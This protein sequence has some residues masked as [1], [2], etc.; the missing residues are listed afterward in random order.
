MN[1]SRGAR[2]R[3]PFLLEFFALFYPSIEDRE[4]KRRQ[5]REKLIEDGSIDAETALDYLS[6]VGEK[7]EKAAAKFDM[8]RISARRGD[9]DQMISYVLEAAPLAGDG[10]S[11]SIARIVTSN[12]P[13][14]DYL[15]EIEEMI[16][17]WQM[18]RSGELE[19]FSNRLNEI[20]E[21]LTLRTFSR[22]SSPSCSTP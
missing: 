7:G 9:A 4:E 8:A 15:A 10:V 19:Q 13:A 18:H 3:L 2:K 12:Q 17:C 6:E 14:P 1:L 16:E 5:L 21:G 11:Q 20:G 22:L